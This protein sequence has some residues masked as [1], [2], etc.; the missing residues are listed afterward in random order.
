MEVIL[1][2]KSR[3]AVG[4]IGLG[5]SA[6]LVGTLVV[7][8]LCGVAAYGGHALAAKQGSAVTVT[9]VDGEEA[10]LQRE[11]NA[12]RE[13]VESARE[14]AADN[15]NA[16]TQRLGT[17]QAHVNR[18][19]ALGERLAD[20]AQLPEGEFH[21]GDAPGRGGPRDAETPV[22]A[23]V[24]D[25]LK[26]LEELSRQLEDRGEQ[27]GALE[28]LLMDRKLQASILPEGRPV[29]AGYISSRFGRRTDPISGRADF[30]TGVDF[31]SRAGSEVLAVAAGVVTW[32]DRRWE[33]GY[34]VEV[35]HGNGY[36]TRYAHNKKNL[37]KVGDRV[38]KGQP[39][40]IVG[41]TGRSTGPHV[42]FEV[43]QDG[44]IV[45]PMDYIGETLKTAKK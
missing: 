37:V 7:S 32:S 25:F 36:V 33:Y 5:R 11:L 15:L 43:L 42:H 4:R 1:I 31:G 12:Q 20:M 18:L 2:S 34:L 28:H 16:L 30:H 27:L 13:L 26:A 6:F 10:R 29:R 24:P 17:L 40:A 9:A 3:G 41:S 38:D 39:I 45:N 19:D 22:N 8:G 35:N 14:E 23:T 44:K 21:F